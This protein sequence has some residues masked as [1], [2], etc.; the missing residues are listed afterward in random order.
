MKKK[1]SFIEARDLLLKHVKTIGKEKIPLLECF[2]RVLGQD[3]TAN[4]NV[5][6]F[7]RSP[8]DGYA[9]R[10]EDSRNASKEH[11]VTLRVLEEIPAG[12]TPHCQVTKGYAVKI[13]TGAPIPAGADAVIKYEL[14]EFT[15]ETV[16]IF[17]SLQSGSNIIKKGEDVKV[18]EML[19]RKGCH[20]DM[21]VSGTLA[22]Q[23]IAYP[24]VYQ[25]PKI[26]IISTGCELQEIGTLLKNGKIYNSNQY[27]L[28]HALKQFGCQPVILGSANDHT[29][30]IQELIQQG[31]STCDAVILTGGVSAGDYDLT[32]NAMRL[33]G[34]EILFQ[35]VDLKPGMACAYGI[36]NEVLLCGLSGNPAAAITNFYLVA[37]P[38]IRK[39]C[40]YQDP[41]LEEISVVLLDDFKKSNQRT[42][43]LR[44]KLDLSAGT[45]GMHI[46]NSQGNAVISSAIGCNVLAVIPSGNGPVKAGTILKGFLI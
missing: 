36:K 16:T 17:E 45:V 22:A 28:S 25:I 35:G 32:P 13:L 41:L 26:G 39:L 44:G 14:T 9:F 20:I 40:G 30:Q 23:N 7:D 2:G 11:P 37:L 10:A 5:P 15:N 24:V 43:A 33:A 38:A 19:L 21:G 12:S 1:L 3:L 18:N 42:R 31:L 46:P 8:L 4:I 29:E 34:A 27:L 6:P